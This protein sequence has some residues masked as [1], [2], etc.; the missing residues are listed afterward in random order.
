MKLWVIV[1]AAGRGQRFAESVDKGSEGRSAEN[2]LP[3]QYRCLIDKPL[4][5]HT[6]EKLLLV[7]PERM[8][9]AVHPEDRH[10][11]TLSVCDDPR[12]RFVEGGAE[13]A[14][15]VLRAL[16]AVADLAQPNDQVLVHDVARP[17]V[18]VDDI[19][20]LINLAGDHPEGGLLAAALTDTVKR[21]DGSGLVSGTEERESLWAA[22]TPQLCRY[23]LLVS[24]LERARKQGLSIT[25]EA[26]ALE[27]A[28]YRPQ[29]VSGRRDNIKVTFR[30]DMVLAEAIL[31]SQQKE[32]REEAN[33]Q[34]STGKSK[35]A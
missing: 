25:D 34:K 16:F 20:K 3:K 28:G 17:C 26:S 29:V 14:D 2:A 31:L 22:M 4:I 30:E 32:C 15:S 6:L 19:R 18:S 13:R 9:V 1:P 21:V 12:V 23:G 8:V 5:T 11:Q 35:K 7:E 27:A 24:V 33:T 10:W